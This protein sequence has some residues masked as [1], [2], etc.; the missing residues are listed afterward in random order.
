MYHQAMLELYQEVAELFDTNGET[1]PELL[2]QRLPQMRQWLRS[3][4]HPDGQIAL[5]ND[6]AFG[7]VRP[8][9][10]EHFAVH[11]DRGERSL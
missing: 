11:A 1:V 3:V 9:F 7:V 10:F 2:K 4:C 6:A 8:P 5:L